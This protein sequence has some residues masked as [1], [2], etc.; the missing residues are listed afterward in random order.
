MIQSDFTDIFSSKRKDYRTRRDRIERQVQAW[1]L[2]LPHLVTA[3]LKFQQRGAPDV[4]EDDGNRWE[5]EVISLEGRFIF[6][7]IPSKTGI[8]ILTGRGFRSFSH[9]SN[10]V[11]SAV[12]LVEYGVIPASPEQPKLGFSIGTLAFYRQLR[13]VSPR[14]SL[15]AFSKVLNHYHS[16]SPKDFLM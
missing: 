15:D 13:R 11:S 6:L 12:T 8:D 5:I 16:V 10:A 1:K 4:N 9:M 14:F 2:V 7:S 3:F